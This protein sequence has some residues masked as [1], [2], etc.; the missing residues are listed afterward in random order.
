MSRTTFSGPVSALS[1]ETDGAIFVPAKHAVLTGTW[2]DTRNAAGDYVARRSTAAATSYSA[3]YLNSE[4][5][6]KIGSDPNTEVAHDIRGFQVT[7]IDVIY[8]NNNAGADFS[9]APTA[10]INSVV[11]AD[12]TA[13][14]IAAAGGSL[15]GT[16]VV[17]KRANPYIVRITPATPFVI[18]ANTAKTVHVFEVAWPCAAGT[19][20]DIVGIQVIG[21]YNIL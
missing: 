13:N 9:S 16:F 15:T 4:L 20:L 8:V 11:Y 1:A 12:N 18:G 7:A 14:T 2:T 5:L 17:T 6:C 3:F 19:Q 21:S 10:A